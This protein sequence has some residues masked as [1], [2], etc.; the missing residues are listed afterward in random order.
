MNITLNTFGLSL[1]IIGVILL[2][3]YANPFRGKSSF[4][5][6]DEMVK[7]DELKEKYLIH[8]QKIGLTLIGIGFV[9]QIISNYI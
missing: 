2:F 3:K 4:W 8:W 5:T 6:K 7:E 9:L 1:D